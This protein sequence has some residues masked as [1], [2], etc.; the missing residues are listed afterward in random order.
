[1]TL[2]FE[3]AQVLIKDVQDIDN[4]VSE[5]CG[6]IIKNSGKTYRKLAKIAAG[7]KLDETRKHS[8]FA[9][10]S[11]YLKMSKLVDDSSGGKPIELPMRRCTITDFFVLC[12]I[13]QTDPQ[14]YLSKIQKKFGSARNLIDKGVKHEYQSDTG[15]KNIK[16]AAA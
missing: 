12:A 11:H 9:C 6:E 13:T 10:H 8:A 7:L 16:S 15:R 1:M 14:P 2:N 3:D 5:I 4:F